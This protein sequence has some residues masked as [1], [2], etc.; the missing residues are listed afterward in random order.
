M[1]STS[2]QVEWERYLIYTW[3]NKVERQNTAG[4]GS[5]KRAF[6]SPKCIYLIKNVKDH[7]IPEIN[8]SFWL[9]VACSD[10]REGF[11]P[12]SLNLSRSGATRCHFH[13]RVWRSSPCTVNKNPSDIQHL[14]LLSERDRSK[15]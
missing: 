4:M 7:P 6:R 9:K 14:G 10:E 1:I 2:N 15:A 3:S 13:K 11:Q 8:I 12:F 5:L